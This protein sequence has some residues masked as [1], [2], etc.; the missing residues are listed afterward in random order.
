MRPT[1]TFTAVDP[2][3]EEVARL[4]AAH[5]RFCRDRTPLEN[6]HA[7]DLV[8]LAAP[9]V[10][11]HAARVDGEVLAV[12][13]LQDL[14][15]SHLELKSMHVAASAR[16]LGLGRA[17]LEHLLGVARDRR[18][19]RVSLETSAAD[20]FAPARALYRA[21]GFTACGPYGSYEASPQACF[22]T[23]AP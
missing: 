4:L 2:R 5:L 7:L 21:A 8:A 3:T 6:A 13:A 14:G 23:L 17:M 9:A 1:A 15:G 18:C 20:D 22:M 16:R 11:V 19:T 12:G 10:S